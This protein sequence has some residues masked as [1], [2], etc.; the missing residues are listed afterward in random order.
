[1]KTRIEEDF[2]GKVEVPAD[3]YYGIFTVRASKNFQISGKRPPRTFIRMLALVK[4]SAAEANVETGVL[5]ANIGDALAR[6]AEE[7]AKGKFDSEFILD[8]YTAGAGTPFNMNM[9]EVLANRAEEILGGKKGKY[10]L[11]HPNNHANMSQSSNDVIP[12]AIRLALL[13]ESEGLLKHA[14]EL[15]LQLKKKSK[16]FSKVVKVGR[17]HLMDAVPLNVGDELSAF[18]S[19]LE[20]D[21]ERIC[22]A[23]DSL[24]EMNLGATALGS[25]INTHP[26]YRRIVAKRVQANTGIRVFPGRNMFRLTSQVSDFLHFSASLRGLAAIIHKLSNDLKLLSSGPNTAIGEYILPEVEPGSS[27][28][29]GK[30]NPSIPECAEMVANRVFGNDASILFAASGGQLQ[31][32]VQTPLILECASES[33]VLLSNACQMLSKHCISGLGIDRKRIVQHLESSLISATALAPYFGYPKMSQLVKQAQ[34][35]GKTLKEVIV[36]H[37][38]LTPSQYDR[39]MSPARLTR[40]SKKEKL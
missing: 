23:R 33:V 8:A 1:M 24:R 40:P 9:N 12:A 39:L 7:V 2:I 28:M 10:K 32:N 14:N 19:A 16:E 29:P 37:K 15:A 6:A 38:L 17:T 4:K 11:V 31:L 13:A 25:G 27:I 5:P 3:A 22:K 18:S 36:S 35:E 26:A 34:S 21:I 20:I 30:V